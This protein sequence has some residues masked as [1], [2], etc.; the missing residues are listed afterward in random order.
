MVHQS[1]QTIEGPDIT[2]YWQYFNLDRDPFAMSH[3]ESLTYLPSYWEEMLDL[4]QYLV[5]Y[6]NQAVVVT[7]QNG[8]GK[9][10]LADLLLT[11]LGENVHAAKIAAEPN[12]N[13]IRLIEFLSDAFMVPWQPEQSIEQALDSQLQAF[14]QKEKNCLL[15][16]DNAHLL[17]AETLEAL[18]YLISQQSEHQMRFHVLL[19]GES[20]LQQTLHRMLEP[21]EESLVHFLTLESLSL[22]ETQQYLNHRL[23]ASGWQNENPMSEEIVARV[24]RL[25]EGNP[26]RI[27]RIARRFLL[28]MLSEG[29][30]EAGSSWLGRHL[31]K[32][33]GACLIIAILGLLGVWIWRIN[34]AGSSAPSHTVGTAA[35]PTISLNGQPL[36]AMNQKNMETV[37]LSPPKPVAAPTT[38]AAN[39]PP[40]QQPIVPTQVMPSPAAALPVAE[41]NML[42]KSAEKVPAAVAPAP[43]VVPPLTTDAVPVE[44]APARLKK[45]AAPKPALS[46]PVVKKPVSKTAA[47]PV[48]KVKSAAPAQVPSKSA[49][50]NTKAEYTLQLIGLSN[51]EALE[52]FI[53]D[54]NLQG[55]V[56]TMTVQSHGKTLTVVL[57]GR[58][59]TMRDAEQAIPNL[60]QALVNAGPWPRKVPK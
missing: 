24:Y 47:A 26:A 23:S 31:T 41:K 53:I 36:P 49:V 20:A 11:Q 3:D 54:N 13:V 57:Y 43:A 8:I 50:E 27:N 56:R 32:F 28:D 34:S 6:K 33:L 5:H 42:T 1:A 18:L 38:P 14:Q 16:L 59:K 35:A 12:L 10:I 40:V 7:G 9:S 51:H 25:S 21:T 55:K 58:Y 22:E 30:E 37:A 29:E 46:K 44:Q 4:I 45:I 60:P 19:F 15:L 2:N 39:V 48:K 17:P 52:K